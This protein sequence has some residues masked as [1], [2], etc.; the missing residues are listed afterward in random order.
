MLP[1]SSLFQSIFT[2]A[3]FYL[4]WWLIV[5]IPKVFFLNF[6]SW[7]FLWNTRVILTR[8]IL[9][10]CWVPLV[11][12]GYLFCC[13]FIYEENIFNLTPDFFSEMLIKIKCTKFINVGM[14]L[15]RKNLP[16]VPLQNYKPSKW[17]GPLKA[18]PYF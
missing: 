6:W 3:Y 4:S 17:H 11:V 10:I 15:K 16:L 9:C 18:F 2:I 7:I 5:K 8:V 13:L 1:I 12:E 14:I